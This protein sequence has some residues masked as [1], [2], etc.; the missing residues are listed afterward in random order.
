MKKPRRKPLEPSPHSTVSETEFE[1]LRVLWEHGPGT[2]R[3]IDGVLR[4]GGRSWAYTT[5]LTLLQRLEA[6][7]YVDRETEGIAHV[8]RAAVSRETLLS[9][10]LRELA[11]RFTGGAATP[12]VQALV[13]GH[14]FTPDEIEQFRELLDRIE[15]TSEAKKRGRPRGK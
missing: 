2:V 12:L 15:A 7:G 3:Q 1:V 14:R 8:Y 6:K 5:V 10:R 4:A 11:D 9:T 13:A